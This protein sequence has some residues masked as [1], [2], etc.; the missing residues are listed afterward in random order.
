MVPVGEGGE[1]QGDAEAVVIKFCFG[2][3]L[4][5]QQV[6]FITEAYQGGVRWWGVGIGRWFFGGL[7]WKV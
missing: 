5:A 2:L 1:A 3:H 6:R 7:R 4:T